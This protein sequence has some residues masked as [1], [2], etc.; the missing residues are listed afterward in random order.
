MFAKLVKL[1]TIGAAVVSAVPTSGVHPLLK[2]SAYTAEDGV[3]H[4]VIVDKTTNAKLDFVTN[5][6]VCE[7]T[8]GVNQ[9]SGYLSVGNGL[10]MFFWFFEARHNASTAP[11]ATWFNGG[12]GNCS[13]QT[14]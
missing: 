11:L 13:I 6:G 5:S 14:V 9:Y 10:N 1:L 12:P 8:P 4:T 3:E 7:T 2:R